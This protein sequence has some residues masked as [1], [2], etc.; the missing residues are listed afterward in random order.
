MTNEEKYKI[1]EM[2]NSGASFRKIAI[3][4][5]ISPN[6]VKSY[7]L[8][9]HETEDG[10]CKECGKP[11]ASLPKK[12]KKRFC[13]DECRFKWWSKHREERTLKA[14]YNYICP[15]CGKTFTAYGNSHRVYCSRDCSAKGRSQRYGKG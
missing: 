12:K 4:L 7:Y 6:T 14:T 13:C 15:E 9:L 10:V 8:R 5:N 3:A 1:V 2:R 11:I